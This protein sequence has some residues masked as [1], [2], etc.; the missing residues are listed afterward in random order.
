MFF[1]L[2]PLSDPA[3]STMD[4]LEYLIRDMSLEI[5]K[6]NKTLTVKKELKQKG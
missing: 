6:Q 3:K 2:L 4:N 5:I 1:V